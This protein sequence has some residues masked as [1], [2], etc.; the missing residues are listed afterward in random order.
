MTE[1]SKK[2][3]IKSPEFCENVNNDGKRA[4]KL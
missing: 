3:K 2:E 1:R 4:S